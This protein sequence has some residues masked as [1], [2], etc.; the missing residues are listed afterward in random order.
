VLFD[1]AL[2]LPDPEARE[3]RHHDKREDGETGNRRSP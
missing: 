3:G 2:Q 1:P